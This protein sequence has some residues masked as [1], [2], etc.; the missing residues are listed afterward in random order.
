LINAG[1]LCPICKQTEDLRDIADEQ[2]RTSARLN[3]EAEHGR[4]KFK[5][6]MEALSK[7]TDEKCPGCRGNVKSN[8]DRCLRCG[9]RL[10]KACLKPYCKEW[11]FIGFKYC[12]KC[13][14]DEEQ[15]R[16]DLK[17]ALLEEIPIAMEQ[18]RKEKVPAVSRLNQRFSYM[19]RFADWE[20]MKIMEEEG[21]IGPA[22]S[23]GGP[24]WHKVLPSD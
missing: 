23:G 22:G 21:L 9:E 16:A 14:L 3:S 24:L 17:I 6:E 12:P 7:I 15:A 10:Q 5:D 1:S 4:A 20:A 11:F 2:G 13:G 18:F 19:G 8:Q